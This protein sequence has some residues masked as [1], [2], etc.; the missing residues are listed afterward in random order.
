[1]CEGESGSKCAEGLRCLKTC[2]MGSTLCLVFTPG[3]FL[4]T[5]RTVGPE[6]KLCIFPFKYD[7]NIYNQCTAKDSDLGVP[8][9]ATE[10][11]E[12]DNH[13]ID[14]EWGDC[15]EACPDLGNKDMVSKLYS[16]S[17]QESLVMSNI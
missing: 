17:S 14:N 10:V 8:W 11:E 5:C 13:V 9:C 2:G 6:S 15:V 1:M 16:L 4:G 3:S 12:D 7:G